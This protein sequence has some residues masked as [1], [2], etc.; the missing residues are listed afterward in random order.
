VKDAVRDYSRRNPMQRFTE[1]AVVSGT[2]SYDL[3]SDFVFLI[4]LDVPVGDEGVMHTSSGLVP[5]S[6]SFDERWT[7]IGSQIVFTPTP[8]YTLDRSL[9]Y[10]A[11]HV[12]SAGV[13]ATLTEA[14]AA[15][16]LLKA[17]ALA[18]RKQAL[19]VVTSTTGEIVEYAIGDERVKKMSPGTALKAMAKELEAE[20]LERVKVMVGVQGS[21]ARYDVTGTL[22]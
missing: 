15:V 20:Y 17:Q 16:V 11:G 5:L 9:Q 7:V 3:P 6:Q 10:A 2:A 22:R 1:I 21:R 8:T 12:L 4:R 18:L 19:S 14:D 13:Y